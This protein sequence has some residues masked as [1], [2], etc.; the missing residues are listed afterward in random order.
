MKGEYYMARTKK[1]TYLWYAVY[2]AVGYYA[3]CK[4]FAKPTLPPQA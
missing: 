2:A 3:Y 4:W 1:N